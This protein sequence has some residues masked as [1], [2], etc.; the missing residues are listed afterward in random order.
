ME[1]RAAGKFCF[2]CMQ[3][4]GHRF[5]YGPYFDGDEAAKSGIDLGTLITAVF[6]EEAGNTP[7]TLPSVVQALAV[8]IRYDI[9]TMYTDGCEWLPSLQTVSHD[10]I[11][12]IKIINQGGQVLTD[13]LIIWVSKFPKIDGRP[14]GSWRANLQAAVRLLLGVSL[15][16][17][18][19]SA[20]GEFG[21]KLSRS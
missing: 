1:R 4:R 19:S 6:C 12:Q 7:E 14:S 17:H 5:V 3:R 10:G 21:A 18:I 15:D 20:I 8:C 9:L 2:P 16:K 13:E 11:N